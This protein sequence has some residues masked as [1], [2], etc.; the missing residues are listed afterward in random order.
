LEWRIKV[1]LEMTQRGERAGAL[2]Y[3]RFC[4]YATARLPMVHARA[5]EGRDVSFLRPEQAVMPELR[6]LVPE[7]IED[8]D[9]L[10]AGT[11][12]FGVQGLK[13]SL[14]ALYDFRGIT[15]ASLR[16]CGA[17]VPTPTAWTPYQP[18]C[19]AT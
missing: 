19:M 14:A 4:A 15:L 6:R 16:S 12:D 18:E 17:P 13:K 8:L 9:L 10:F 5:G 2:F 7:I 3:L 1:A 11:R